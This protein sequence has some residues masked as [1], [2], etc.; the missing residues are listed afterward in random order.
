MN[1]LETI[2]MPWSV[3]QTIWNLKVIKAC[4]QGFVKGANR[5]GKGEQDAEEVAFDF[6]R[7]I[8]ALER[9]E[10]A[11]DSGYLKVWYINSVSQD[12]DP[13]WT[14]AHIAELCNDFILIPKEME[15]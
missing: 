9:M 10:R 11:V 8:D 5:E 15:K 3:Q 1:D 13:V 2:K 6:D 4:Y 12:D 14:E 7:A